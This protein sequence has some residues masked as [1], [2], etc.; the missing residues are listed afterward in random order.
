MCPEKVQDSGN[1]RG[2]IT[3]KMNLDDDDDDDDDVI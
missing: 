3:M 1:K 2:I